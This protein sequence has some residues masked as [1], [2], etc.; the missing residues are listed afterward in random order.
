MTRLKV[1]EVQKEINELKRQKKRL[2]VSIAR[3]QG[4]AG[5]I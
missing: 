4:T 3:K 2:S 1:Q 5:L